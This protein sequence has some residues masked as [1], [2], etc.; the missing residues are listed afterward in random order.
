MLSSRLARGRVPSWLLP[1][2][3]LLP[4]ARIQ[5]RIL[6]H[7]QRLQRLKILPQLPCLPR[8]PCWNK[9]NFTTVDHNLSCL[10]PL[11]R[12]PSTVMLKSTWDQT[13]NPTREPL[14]KQTAVKLRASLKTR[15]KDLLSPLHPSSHLNHR[16]RST[17]VF[18]DRLCTVAERARLLHKHLLHLPTTTMSMT[19]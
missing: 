6:L 4:M 14:W 2:S 17:F 19:R 5:L 18:T 12:L 15:G 7:L 8:L 10:C 9:I 1:S 16:T 13:M 11:L 3:Q